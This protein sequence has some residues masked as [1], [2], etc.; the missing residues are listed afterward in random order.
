M[1]Q[2]EAGAAD[3]VHATLDDPVVGALS[4]SVG[5]PV[6][7]H[8]GRARWWTPVRVL[9]LLT[10]VTFVL[11]MVQ[12]APCSVVE[13]KDQNWVYSHM[14]YTDLRPLYVPR[15]L[16]EAA[17]PYSGEEETRGRYEVMEYPAGIAYWAWGTAVLTQWLTGSPDLSARGDLPVS[18]LY[19]DPDVD[20]E[21]TVFLLVNAVGF[22][23]LALLSVWLLA[24]THPRRPWDAAAF[25][26]SPALLLTGLINWDLLAVVL[27]AAALWAWSR[28]RP[29]LTGVLIGLGTAVKL[30]PLFLLGGLLVICLRRRHER[31]QMLA[32]ATAAAAALVAWLIANGPG[33]LTGAAQ[34]KVFWSFNADRAADLGSLWM[35]I[36]QAGNVGFSAE[37]INTWSWILFGAW[38]AVVLALGLTAGRHGAPGSATDVVPRLAQLGYLIVVGFLIV[39]KVYSPQYVLWLLP[40]AVLARPRWRDQLVWQA[41]EVFYFCTV[42]W[43]LGGYLA[44]AG[45]GDAGFYWVGIA[46]RVACELYLAA[47]IVRDM[48]APAHDPVREPVPDVEA[49]PLSR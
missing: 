1:A 8:A 13:G 27:V 33:Y 19:G 41:G 44:P 20:R 39:N 4:E 47:V 45:G 26:L 30:Y 35:L 2:R 18:E 10:A 3:H 48:Y 21:Q 32:F 24:R 23:A 22:A 36:D 28:D 5:G 6:G 11:G 15:G 46:V 42:W 40:L 34:W 12:K 37:T 25:A 17:W 49:S 38:C 14:C 29:L 43:Y 9:L 16:A 31:G 7:E